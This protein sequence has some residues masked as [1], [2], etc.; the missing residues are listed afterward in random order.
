MPE[1]P[2]QKER[3]TDVLVQFFAGWALVNN[4][5]FRRF[6]VAV[7]SHSKISEPWLAWKHIDV[8]Q[9]LE[10]VLH[11]LELRSSSQTRPSHQIPRPVQPQSVPQ[12]VRSSTRDPRMAAAGLRV[13]PRAAGAAPS[14][15]R[16][17]STASEVAPRRDAPTEPRAATSP[18]R[19]SPRIPT[20]PANIHQA[21]LPR[22]SSDSYRPSPLTRTASDSY[23]PSDYY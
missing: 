11:H 14:V 21:D 4:Y 23:R 5:Q 15:P 6:T 16:A 12:L 3:N 7:A 9:G 17:A 22:R 2:E 13:P 10:Q 8:K 18:A 1:T 20:G 19:D